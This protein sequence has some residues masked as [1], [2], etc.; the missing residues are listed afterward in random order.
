MPGV[1]FSTGSVFWL[2]QIHNLFTVILLLSIIVHLLA[3]LLKDNRPLAA[4]MFT[5][6]IDRDYVIHRHSKWWQKMTIAARLE[7]ENTSP[8]V[9]E[10]KIM[11][12]GKGN[13][14]KD[15]DVD[16]YERNEQIKI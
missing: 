9:G 12:A 14:E 4:S 1:Y 7:P 8:T 2:A 13:T 16:A 5:G 6:K 3:F 15:I 10:E 11:M